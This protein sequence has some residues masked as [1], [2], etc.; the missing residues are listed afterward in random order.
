MLIQRECRLPGDDVIVHPSVQ[1]KDAEKIFPRMTIVKPY[2]RFTPLPREQ[3]SAAVWLDWTYR[4]IWEAEWG[5]PVSD[6]GRFWEERL[7][8]DWYNPSLCTAGLG[9][10]QS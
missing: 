6:L 3:T 10:A 5:R 4:Q 8:Y 1:T 7:R 9:E 2:L